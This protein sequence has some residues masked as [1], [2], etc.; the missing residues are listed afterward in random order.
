VKKPRTVLLVEDDIVV[1]HPI[2][3]YL[4]QCGFKVFEAAGGDEAREALTTP[5]L[6][7]DV[8]LADM[9][10]R[11]GGFGLQ[12]WIREQDL[13][14]EVILAGSLEKCVVHAGELCRESGPADQTLRT[15]PRARRDTPRPRA[16]RSPD[17]TS[18]PA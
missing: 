7:I 15:P 9:T 8:V 3:E 2:A 5:D 10:T 1:R 18:R 11:G 12:S 14:V 4:R 6:A 13:A 16:A 17:L